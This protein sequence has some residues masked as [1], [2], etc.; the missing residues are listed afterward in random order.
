MNCNKINIEDTGYFTSL[1]L[2]YIYQSKALSSF[3]NYPPNL[4]SFKNYIPQREF[5]SNK[6]KLL[7]DTLL[8]QYKGYDISQEVRT[9]LDNLSN[10]RTF[11]VTT[12]H[13]LNVFTGPLYTIYKIVTVIN[14]AR[15][16][17]EKYPEYSFVP[18]YWLASEDHDLDEICSVNIFG[19]K[20]SWETD[21]T[22]PVG[23]MDP[24]SL[25]GVL[26]QMP[27]KSDLFEYAYK[28][29]ET[30]AQ[31]VRYYVNELFGEYGLLILDGDEGVFKETFRDIMKDDLINHHANDLVETASAQLAKAGYKT[32]VYPRTINLFYMKDGLRKRIIREDGI[33]KIVDTDLK[34]SEKEIL[35][36]LDTK[37]EMFSP[38]VILRPL[39]QETILPNLAYI[40]GPAEIAYWLQLK[41]M[42]DY[43][44]IQFPVLLPRNFAMIINVGINKKLEKLQIQINDLFQP[45]QQLKNKFIKDHT[46]YSL[47]LESEKKILSE[48]FDSVLNKALAVDKSLQG[49]IGA[50]KT[51]TIKNIENI[52]K[53]LRKSEENK[54]EVSLNQIDGIK[55]KLFPGSNLQ[56]RVDNILSYTLNNPDLIDDLVENFDPFDFRFNV[57]VE[58]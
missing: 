41:N 36:L 22:G 14:T 2:D 58:D 6:R 32:Q 40:G 49:Y 29:K 38:N 30:L 53:R 52:E 3:Q 8:S 19:R 9:N 47:S 39:Y 55:E 33:Y 25:E 4:E 20:Y 31:S 56:E 5:D 57:F 35:N 26:N 46:E 1:Y 23:R 13:Q 15:K 12:G 21:Q 54:Q 10:E 24:S 7:F 42:F 28:N 48:L 27:E 51:K 17:N 18:V 45:V 16:L 37:P 50:E 11:T 43:Y 44:S 34:F